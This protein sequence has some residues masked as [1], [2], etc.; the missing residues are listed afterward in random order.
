MRIK[1][2]QGYFEITVIKGVFPLT[3]ELMFPKKIWVVFNNIITSIITD[4]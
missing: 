3:L 4:L 1:F 2:V